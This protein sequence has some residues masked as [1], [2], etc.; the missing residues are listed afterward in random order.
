MTADQPFI[1]LDKNLTTITIETSDK[2]QTGSYQ[3]MVE[4]QMPT[5]STVKSQT[6]NVVIIE[7]YPDCWDTDLIAPDIPNYI[8]PKLNNSQKYDQYKYRIPYSHFYFLNATCNKMM[9]ISEKILDTNG[10][11]FQS[12]KC[13]QLDTYLRE[14]IV[15][16]N[17]C[18]QDIVYEVSVIGQVIIQKDFVSIS[19]LINQTTFVVLN[20][21]NKDCFTQ[22]IFA[23]ESN[24]QRT[25]RKFYY[26]IASKKEDSVEPADY[27]IIIVAQGYK[28]NQ[29]K[30][31]VYVTFE[32]YDSS[33]CKYIPQVKQPST[34]T[35]P[36]KGD[37]KF[38]LFNKYYTKQVY[39]IQDYKFQFIGILSPV[40]NITSDFI[41]KVVLYLKANTEAPKFSSKLPNIVIFSDYEFDFKLPTK[42]DADGNL[43]KMKFLTDQNVGLPNF[44]SNDTQNLVLKMKPSIRDLGTY[45]VAI[46]LYDEDENSKALQ[47][48]VKGLNI[49]I[50]PFISKINV[51]QFDLKVRTSKEYEEDI[52]TNA[53]S[54]ITFRIQQIK[55][56]GLVT[57]KFSE[58]IEIDMSNRNVFQRAIQVNLQ[59]PD[60]NQIDE[61]L[62]DLE[63]FDKITLKIK[64]RLNQKIVES[65]SVSKTSINIRIVDSSIFTS[66]T[67]F[68]VNTKLK[69]NNDA[70]NFTTMD[71]S[72]KDS[73]S[74]GFKLLQ[75]SV[76][77]FLFGN[78]AVNIILSSSIQMLWGMINAFQLIVLMTLF[79]LKITGD[80]LYFF[81]MVAQLSSFSLIPTDE[82][83]HYFFDFSESTPISENFS[84]MDIFKSIPII[85]LSFSQLFKL[86]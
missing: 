31:Y 61:I 33:K 30:A 5:N 72:T 76:S 42:S 71:D 60:N 52:I 36:N 73:I 10:K 12:D 78:L 27:K 79:N 23:P 51:Y 81:K 80:V 53:K 22:N 2:L 11:S 29:I 19:V 21:S 39:D 14:F 54:R 86:Y 38:I 15:N 65:S 24:A 17:D 50:P 75:N 18:D 66:P 45:L 20:T 69:I 3:Y 48:L 57:M 56:N 16:I 77:S 8:F 44:V 85:Y 55:P 70:P 63:S 1:K 6:F 46:I 59:N 62:W 68:T 4:I 32:V 25:S 9:Q 7:D 83:V 47:D 26:D 35:Y 41:L 40:L 67:G 13:L 34:Y 37:Q 49:V 82:Y 84:S 74:A 64:L 28:N 43:I 58:L